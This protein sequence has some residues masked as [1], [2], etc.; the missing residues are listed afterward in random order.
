MAILCEP[1]KIQTETLPRI[2]PLEDSS[3]VAVKLWDVPYV[4]CAGGALGAHL[5]E[6]G[7]PIG[8]TELNSLPAV[9]TG[10][11][12]RFAGV[13]PFEPANVAHRIDEFELA[14]AAVGLG[15]GLAYLPKDLAMTVGTEVQLAGLRPLDKA[16]FAVFLERRLLST[17][18][19]ALIEWLKK[20]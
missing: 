12:W 9:F 11:R 10:Q 20:S 14:A 4:I 18:L 3:L 7:N 15:L 2:G 5:G 13:A 1:G 17:H 16:M 19:R 6:A 8:L